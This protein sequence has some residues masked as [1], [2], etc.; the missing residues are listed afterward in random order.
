[1][2][3]KTDKAQS[4]CPGAPPEPGS[5]LLGV[6]VKPGQIVYITPN[7]PVSQQMLDAL[8]IHSIPPENRMGFAGRCMQHRCAQWAGARCGLIDRVADHFG[9]EKGTSPLPK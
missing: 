6:V 1:M 4:T 3:I 7:P 2:C 5:N 9:G 8:E